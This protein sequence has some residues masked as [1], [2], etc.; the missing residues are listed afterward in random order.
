MSEVTKG[1][2]LLLV[3]IDIELEYEDEFNRWYNEE[4]FPERLE[5][6]GFIS[7]RRYVATEGAPKY[8]AIYELE[9]IDV[10]SAEDYLRISPPSEWSKNLR[11]HFLTLTRNIYQDITP[12]IPDGYRVKA[13][14][15]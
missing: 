6:P 10:L 13:V 4:H 1:S 8:L 2:G 14:R 15:A 9:N 7:A 11:P 5:C 12:T 3:M